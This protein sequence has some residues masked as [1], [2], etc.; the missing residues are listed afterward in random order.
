VWAVNPKND[1][2]DA[3][4]NFICQMVDRLCED[5][6][7][8]HRLK[9]ADLPSDV[10]LSSQLR[11]NLILAVKEAVHNVIKHARASELSVSVD[12]DGQILTIGVE[13]NGCGVDPAKTG[14]GN[15]L[16]NMQRRLESSGGSFS[17]RSTP[18]GG[19]TVIFRTAIRPTG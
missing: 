4:G 16:A 13:D 19:A 15:G 10:P 5:A 8:P 2:L 14:S 1:N 18:G 11:H 12:W 6:Q 9:V 17:L 3:L 7:L